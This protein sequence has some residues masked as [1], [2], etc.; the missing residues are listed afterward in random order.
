MSRHCGA[1]AQRGA[2]VGRPDTSTAPWRRPQVIGTRVVHTAQQVPLS[3]GAR[4]GD[5]ARA[6]R[7]A[8]APRAGAARARRWRPHSRC[9]RPLAC[10]ARWPAALIK[11]DGKDITKKGAYKKNRCGMSG[12]AGRDPAAATARTAG[13]ST[14]A[15]PSPLG[16]HPPPPGTCS[17]STCSWRRRRPAAWCA[18]RRRGRGLRRTCRGGGAHT[19]QAA[20][21]PAPQPTAPPPP[22]PKH[23]I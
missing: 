16:P 11:S 10:A 18:R 19:V 21:S 5:R 14:P 17:S 7:G 15:H 8:R 13:S 2:Q 20:A 4:P 6:G 9:P 12:L 1:P 22:S 3:R 23:E